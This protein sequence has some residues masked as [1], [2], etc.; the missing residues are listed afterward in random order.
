MTAFGDRSASRQY[1]QIEP[2][3]NS[4]LG[5]VSFWVEIRDAKHVDRSSHL[6]MIDAGEDLYWL[7]AILYWT[8]RVELVRQEHW[9]KCSD[10][11]TF[12]S[13]FEH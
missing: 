8:H 2:S 13:R 6:Y 4:D 7:T 5:N 9:A 3:V 12:E 1:V 11:C 10:T